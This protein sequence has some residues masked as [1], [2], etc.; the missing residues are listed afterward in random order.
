L[1]FKDKKITI[2]NMNFKENLEEYLPKE[3]VDSL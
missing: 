2:N 1:N 3:F